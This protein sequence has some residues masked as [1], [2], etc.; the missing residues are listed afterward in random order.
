MED[1]NQDSKAEHYTF[2]SKHRFLIFI[3]G[4]LLI[5]FV[6]VLASMEMY[7]GSGAAQLDLSRPGYMSVRSMAGKNEDD[8]QSFSSSGQISK[9][10]INQFKALYEKQSKKIKDVDAFVSDPLSPDALG[11]SPNSVQ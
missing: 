2:T 11:I 6:I 5:S 8:F 4:S 1:H 10:I 7:N 9:D 3:C